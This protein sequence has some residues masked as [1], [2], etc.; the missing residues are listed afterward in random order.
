MANPTTPAGQRLLLRAQSEGPPAPVKLVLLVLAAAL[1]WAARDLP[2]WTLELTAPQYPGGLVATA[3]LHSFAGDVDELNILNHY[4]GMMRFE[5]AAQLERSLVPYMVPAISVLTV[6]SCFATGL[7]A[8]LLRLPMVTFPLVFSADLAA[9]LYHAGHSLDPRAPLS[10]AI[11]EFTP[12]FLGPGKIAQFLTVAYFEPGF[13]L[14][15]AA[16]ALTLVT[17][18]WRRRGRVSRGR[19][20][21]GAR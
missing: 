18:L 15:L 16:A 13:Y 7:W 5:D 9:W 19:V 17:L 4:I 21:P 10:Q 20:S 2:W 14:A 6:L 8:W 1:F 3:Y 12:H 11:G